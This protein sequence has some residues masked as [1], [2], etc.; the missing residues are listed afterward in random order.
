MNFRNIHAPL[1]SVIVVNYNYER[2]IEEC[3]H[4]IL[5]QTYPYIECII[6]DNASTDFSVKKID[7]IVDRKDFE[8]DGRSL[9]VIKSKINLHQTAGSAEAFKQSSP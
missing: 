5:N 9:S 3:L 7:M 4:S 1:V 6:I 2:F 8:R